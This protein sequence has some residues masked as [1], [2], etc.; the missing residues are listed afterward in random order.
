MINQVLR[1]AGHRAHCHWTSGLDDLRSSLGS[2]DPQLIVFFTD[3]IPQDV[4]AVVELRRQ[5]DAR[6]PLIVVGSGC[7]EAAIADALSAGA[8]DRVSPERRDR[9]QAVATREMRAFRLERALERTLE[10]ATRYKAQLKNYMADAVDAIADIQEGIVVDANPSWAELVG[11]DTPENVHGPIMDAVDADSQA[12][13]KG[14]LLACQKGRWKDTPLHISI[15]RQSGQSVA[16]DVRLEPMVLDGEAAI[17]L[18]VQQPETPEI[19]PETLVESSVRTDP[20][21]GM[22]HRT[23]FLEHLAER[24][25]ERAQGA[26]AVAM[27][28]LDRFREIQ[29]DVGPVSSEAIIEQAA[30]IVREAAS[31]QDFCGRF[32]GTSFAVLLERGAFRDIV[33][34]GDNLTRRLS[35]A[36]I[37]VAG[38]LIPVTCTTGIA[39]VG[40]DTADADQL[41]RTAHDA[42]QR[43]RRAGGNRIVVEEASDEGT[44]IRRFDALWVHQIKSALMHQRF[45]LLHLGLATLSGPNRIMLDTVVRMIDQ[46]GDE[47]AA[48]QFIETARRNEL[49]RPIDRWVLGESI[50]F[51]AGNECDLLFIRLTDSSITDEELVDWIAQQCTEA[52][53]KP[54]RLCLEISETDATKHLAQAKALSKRLRAAGFGFALEHFGVGRDPLRLL[55]IFEPAWVKIDGSLMETVCSDVTVADRIRSYAEAATA[56]GIE[57]IAERVDDANTM[58]VLFQLGIGH[59]QGHYVHE[60]EVVLGESA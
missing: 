40:P 27:I 50:R 51:L 24:L 52:S 8:Q 57:T 41:I 46:Q 37:E 13:L 15:R 53:V 34:W 28:R 7:D 30:A 22:S 58:A 1:Q 54:A 59:I 4:A 20:A 11:H 18:T 39:E 56:A 26:R 33:A 44:Q 38:K 25:D 2:A 29:S 6:I 9:L 49:A 21:T 5:H 31:K 10:S 48:S 12:A 3:S 55:G 36:V 45:K 19:A 60:P 14:A 42:M 32:G 43:G 16:V 23:Y 35:E 47:I 17:R